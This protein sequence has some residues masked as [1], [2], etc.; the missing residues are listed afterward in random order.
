MNKETANHIQQQE[1]KKTG[2]TYERK[3]AIWKRIIHFDAYI[4]TR[5]H[6]RDSVHNK[7]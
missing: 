6:S 1:E 4:N 5:S 3:N 2:S 7:S